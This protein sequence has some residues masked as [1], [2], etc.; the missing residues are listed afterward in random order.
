[1][2]ENKNRPELSEDQLDMVSGGNPAEAQLYLEQLS[3][4]K[5]VELSNIEKH[6]TEEEYIHY[7]HLYTGDHSVCGQ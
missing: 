3:K 7:C 5:G 4:K 2:E 6:M 1:M